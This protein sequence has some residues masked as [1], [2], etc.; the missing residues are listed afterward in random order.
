MPNK[1]SI[2][3]GIM[4]DELDEMTSAERLAYLYQE[5][6][7]EAVALVLQTLVDPTS[8]PPEMAKYL[9]ETDRYDCFKNYR[10]TS[11]ESLERDA[12]E[13]QGMGLP[14]GDLVA[15]AALEARPEREV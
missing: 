12:V 7:P 11:R 3:S 8:A 4:A 10:G 15:A 13:L 2:E 14:V 9:E 1:P 6:G 5:C